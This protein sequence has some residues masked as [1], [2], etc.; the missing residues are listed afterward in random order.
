MPPASKV[1]SQSRTE[2]LID[3]SECLRVLA[4][5]LRLLVIPDTWHFCERVYLQTG[6]RAGFYKDAVILNFSWV[7]YS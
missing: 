5:S 1:S 3:L 7:G 4:I 6:S 2:Q